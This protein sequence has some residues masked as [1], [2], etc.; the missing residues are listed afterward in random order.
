MGPDLSGLSGR[1]RENLL[2][3]IVDPNA[4]IS[5]GYED[6]LI[7]TVDGRSISGVIVQ[8]TD[9][10]VIVR[11]AGGGEDTILRSSIARLR[12]LALSHMPEGLEASMTLQDM[13]DLLHY[14]RTYRGG[15]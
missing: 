12:S 7:E 2:L 6:L 13:A 15:S 3:Q 10:A 8:R 14:L 1:D 11:R 4:S 5:A 9:T